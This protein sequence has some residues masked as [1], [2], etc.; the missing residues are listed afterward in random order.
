MHPTTRNESIK[1][2]VN[3]LR[4]LMQA[5][6]RFTKELNRDYQVSVPQLV[7]L[8]ALTEYGPLSPSRI[9]R[10][11][12]VNSS[13]VTGII[14]RLEQKGLVTRIR[15]S[16]DRRIIKVE[17]TAAGHRLVEKAPLP[18]QQKIVEGL[19][20]LSQPEIDKIVSSLNK[21]VLM[22][23]KDDMERPPKT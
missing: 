9:A 22:L 5:E 1:E 10:H 7:C 17:L 13:T 8:I 16:L 2:I 21:L 20:G 11:I 12:M 4:R 23:D 19:E 14:D 3:L 6:Q 18:I 15:S